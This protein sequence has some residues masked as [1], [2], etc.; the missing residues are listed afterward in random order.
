MA[1]VDTNPLGHGCTKAAADTREPTAVALGQQDC[2]HDSSGGRSSARGWKD[3]ETRRGI[4]ASPLDMLKRY[5]ETPTV[6]PAWSSAHMG[7]DQFQHMWT[8]Q[9]PTHSGWKR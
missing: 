1:S 3:V 6:R 2:P 9:K 7:K 4:H 5:S 8:R